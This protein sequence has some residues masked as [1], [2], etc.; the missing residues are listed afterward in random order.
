MSS[1]CF[2]TK[3]LDGS[4]NIVFPIQSADN[5]TRPKWVLGRAPIR[6]VCRYYYGVKCDT[7]G[8]TLPGSDKAEITEQC[9][10]A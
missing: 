5:C 10:A 9:M 8:T 1:V 4:Q 3:K 2:C 6:F 7:S